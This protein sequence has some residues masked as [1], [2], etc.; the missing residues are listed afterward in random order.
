LL[1]RVSRGNKVLFEPKHL[2]RLQRLMVQADAADREP[3]R[4]NETDKAAQYLRDWARCLKSAS[5]GR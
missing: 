2:E 3:D 4:L 5:A 1:G